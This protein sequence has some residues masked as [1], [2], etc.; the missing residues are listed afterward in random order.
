MSLHLY[1]L[2]SAHPL[3]CNAFSLGLLCTSDV[4]RILIQVKK[5]PRIYFGITVGHY[6]M[7]FNTSD[8]WQ[9]QPA[10]KAVYR[11]RT[12]NIVR[13]NYRLNIPCNIRYI[14]F[15]GRFCTDNTTCNRILKLNWYLQHVLEFLCHSA[16]TALDL[17]AWAT[18]I[19]KRLGH[20]ILNKPLPV[21]HFCSHAGSL[22]FCQADAS[23][24]L[25]S[26]RAWTGG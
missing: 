16:C 13:H 9:Y 12:S 11:L 20:S 3:V 17:S 18:A 10:L 7:Y 4:V 1:W 5:S 21:G 25:S 6:N 22:A 19:S 23:R 2:L 24:F 14:K 15:Y 26:S 8:L